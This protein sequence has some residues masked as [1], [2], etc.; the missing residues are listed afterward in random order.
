MTQPQTEI[1]KEP[2]V[3]IQGPLTI[4]IPKWIYDREITSRKR[5]YTE[6]LDEEFDF[7]DSVRS[8]MTSFTLP[9]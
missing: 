3:N 5:G 6:M 7:I 4:R 2:V 9:G 8:S 1:K